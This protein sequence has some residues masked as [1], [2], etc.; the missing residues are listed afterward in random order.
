MDSSEPLDNDA[1]K[2]N[3]LYSIEPKA[4]KA[5]NKIV[6]KASKSTS[7]KSN[8]PTVTKDVTMDPDAMFKIGF[9]SDVYNERPIKIEG[10]TEVV[11]RFPP[12][13]N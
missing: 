3:S 2:N 11:T 6:S 12:E 10:I 13:P 9:L 4:P 5:D 8:R 7:T 1:A